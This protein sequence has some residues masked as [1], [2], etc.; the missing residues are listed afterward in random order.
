MARCELEEAVEEEHL[1]ISF[2]HFRKEIPFP[3]ADSDSKILLSRVRAPAQ[4]LVSKAQA[5]SQHHRSAES[6][7]LLA[8]N[9]PTTALLSLRESSPLTVALSGERGSSFAGCP[10]ELTV[11]FHSPWHGACFNACTGDIEDAPGL[12]NLSS[13]KV[14]EEGSAL[15]LTPPESEDVTATREPPAFV[16][17]KSGKGVVIVGGGAGAAHAVEELREAGYEGRIRVVS[18]EN[19]LPIDRTKLSKAL[20]ADSSKIAL[21]SAE[22]YEKL[23][24]EFLL[25]QVSSVAIEL[26]PCLRCDVSSRSAMTQEASSFDGEADVLSLKNGDKIEYE[27]LIVATGASPNRLPVDGADLENIFVLRTVEHSAAIDKGACSVAT[28]SSYAGS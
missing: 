16:S 12:N 6:T 2:T 25:G 22:F 11:L 8:R 7:T 1:L 18:S 9:V 13:F 20:I 26:G 15:F 21:R 27:Q 5:D 23:G 19:Y 14:E 17:A 28:Q 3:K 24:V 4:H 10:S